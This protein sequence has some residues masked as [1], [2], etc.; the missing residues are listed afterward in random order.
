MIMKKILI[1]PDSFKE[2][3][4]SIEVANYIKEFLKEKYNYEYVVKPIADGGEGTIEALRASLNIQLIEKEVTGPNFEK[5]IAKIGVIND[6][7]AIIESAEVVGFKHKVS[8]SKAG[9][10]TSYGLGEL[11]NYLGEAGFTKIYIG[12]GGTITND[13]GVG[14]LSALG[15]KFINDSGECFIP[16]GLTLSNIIN[17]DVSNLKQNIKI[18]ILS[19]VTNPLY[20]E[21]GATYIYGKQKGAS[22]N[23]L[24]IMEQGMINYSNITNSVLK[25]DETMTAGSGSAGGLGYS[26]ISY[27]NAD[28]S[29][30]I[31]KVLELIN[32]EEEIKTADLVITGEGKIDYQSACGKAI[33]GV[34]ELCKKN[35][36]DCIAICGYLDGNVEEFKKL[37][38]KEIYPTSSTKR[39]LEEIKKTCVSDLRRAVNKIVI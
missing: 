25:K 19:D 6:T 39:P 7:E 37:G 34:L 26:F 32:F 35:E 17:I 15:V 11:I 36:T 3:F 12:L 21:N 22:I 31:E 23:E 33:S 2:T 28:I 8:S 5:V 30:G 18:V 10:T 27:L 38:L 1:A 20:G 14:A 9:T 4:S 24:D 13:G 29:S 16:T